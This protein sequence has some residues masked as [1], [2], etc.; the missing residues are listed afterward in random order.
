MIE[1]RPL[2]RAAKA[3]CAWV[4]FSHGALAFFALFRPDLMSSPAYGWVVDVAPL[5][6]WGLLA[7]VISISA[8][9]ARYTDNR[10]VAYFAVVVSGWVSFM[11]GLS[12][13]GLSL[14]G[15]TSAIT[16]SIAW[17]TGTAISWW[18]AKEGIRSVG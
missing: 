5:W 6:A 18:F 17:W 12:L 11:F 2:P 1:N 8:A 15:V 7:M 9:L 13:F 10:P 14:E 3:W 4:A 16:G